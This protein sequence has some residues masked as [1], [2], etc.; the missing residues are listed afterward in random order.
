RSEICRKTHGKVHALICT[1]GTGSTI[2][3]V[4]T[5]LREQKND[6]VIGVADP[7]G[8]GMYNFFS[9]GE[10]KASEG[11][12]ITEGIGL[13]RVT[14]IIADI[15]VDKAYLIPDEEAAPIIFDLLEHEDL[16]V[17]GASG[18]MVA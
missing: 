16:C 11:G 12:S 9:R 2:D 14:P 17:G 7:R 6:I 1:T 15:K 3:G 8:A 10:A 4:S 18:T 5:Y 13:N